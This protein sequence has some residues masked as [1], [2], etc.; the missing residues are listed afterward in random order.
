MVAIEGSEEDFTSRGAGGGL[1]S[2]SLSGLD[3]Y[4]N[5]FSV[6]D[7]IENKKSSDRGSGLCLPPFVIHSNFVRHVCF[8]RHVVGHLFSM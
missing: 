2:K 1:T 7:D 6:L 8:V 5:L 4:D 3:A